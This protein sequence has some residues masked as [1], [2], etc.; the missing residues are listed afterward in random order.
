MKINTEN[1][2]RLA[3]IEKNIKSSSTW[4]RIL[5]MSL[6]IGLWGI[7]RVVIFIIMIAQTF[8]VLF[9]GKRQP[10]LLNFSYSLAA[11]SYQIIC[12]LT[13]ISEVQP[14]PFSEWPLE[15]DREVE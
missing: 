8:F 9:T 5:F 7:S 4:L 13:Y 6:Y 15:E 14:F 11:Y 1:R 3:I 10:R 12:Y 2:E